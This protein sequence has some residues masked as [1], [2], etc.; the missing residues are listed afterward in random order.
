MSLTLLGQQTARSLERKGNPM[1]KDHLSRRAFLGDTVLTSA[2]SFLAAC[3]GSAPTPTP[4]PAPPATSAAVAKPT[5][6]P[7]TKPTDTPV[8]TPTAVPATATPVAQAGGSLVTA[9]SAEP[10]GIDPCNPWNLGSGMSGVLSLLY[11]PWMYYNRQGKLQPYLATSW[12]RTAPDTVVF[13]LP[14]GVKYH[15][16][17]EMVAADVQANYERET[18][19]DLACTRLNQFNASVVSIKAIDKY[20]FEVKTKDLNVLPQRIPLPMMIDPE[21]V[22]AQSQPIILHGEAGTGPWMLKDWV[23]QTSISYQKNPNYWQKPPLIDEFR[24]QIMPEEQSVVAAMRAGQINY[25]MISK[26]ENYAQLKD[27]PS[28]QTWAYPGNGYTRLNVNHKRPALQDPNVLQA[29]LHGINRKQLVDTMTHGLG[30]VSGP[31]APVITTFALP[32]AELDELQKYDPEL[33]KSLLAKAGYNLKDKRLQLV[34]LSIAGFRDW[35]DIVQVIQSNLKDIG[36]DLEIRIQEL[37]VWVDNRVKKG[38]YDLSINDLGFGWDP[39]LLYY[40][41]DQVEAQWTGGG[42][43]EVDKLIN[44]SNTEEDPAKRRELILEI[45]RHLIKNVREIFLYAP[46]VF[47]AAS[48]KLVGYK[49][50]PLGPGFLTFTLDQVSVQK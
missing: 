7:A 36:I 19:K 22:K 41:S 31:I 28:V 6:T 49:P 21:Y 25:M 16:G 32:Q 48:K 17:R 11:D 39:N 4:S 35:T 9:I 50:W 26:Y 37:G 8:P 40:R 18:K 34:C 10:T 23:P 12:T 30:Q 43:P 2:L 27:E 14:Q 38:D 5:D 45:Q 1:I 20:K 42:D 3:T 24:M 15:T 44:A 46:P 13:E 33:A 29:L 47:E